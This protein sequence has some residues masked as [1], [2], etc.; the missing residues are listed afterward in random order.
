VPGTG[1]RAGP[2][3]GSRAGPLAGPARR[4]LHDATGTGSVPPVTELTIVRHAQSTWN[5]EHRW[6]GIADPPL[7][8]VGEEQARRAGDRMAFAPDLLVTSDLRRAVRTG[9]L[10]TAARPPIEVAVDPD[11]REYDAGE[12]TGLRRD[13]I[14]A[15]WP[16][17][18]ARWDA[19][20]LDRAPGGEDGDAFL[21]RL[22]AAVDRLGQ[23]VPTGRVLA[24]SHGRAVHVLA[25]ALGGPG[26]YID[27]LCGW[28]LDVVATPVLVARVDLSPAGTG[29]GVT[30]GRTPEP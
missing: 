22:L 27:H 8:A 15:R 1:S 2:G 7:S 16:G 9:E 26:G 12:W 18:L 28:A 29:G 5:A 30:T 25:T 6:Q 3:T 23:R 4:A 11:L 13:E 10:L 21:A 14:A 20:L 19:G 17:L 24:V